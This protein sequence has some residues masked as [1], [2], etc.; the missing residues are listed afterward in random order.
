MCDGIKEGRGLQDGKPLAFMSYLHNYVCMLGDVLGNSKIQVCVL[1][2]FWGKS[3]D[4]WM[5]VFL[6]GDTSNPN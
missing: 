1:L 2:F 3:S 4:V 6:I 5:Y